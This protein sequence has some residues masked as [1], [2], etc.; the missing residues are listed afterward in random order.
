MTKIPM[1]AGR[2]PAFAA[3]HILGLFSVF[4]LALIG[5]AAAVLASPFTAGVG[6][7]KIVTSSGLTAAQK[8]ETPGQVSPDGKTLLFRQKI[9]RLLAVTGPDNDMLSYR[10][11]GRRNPT[12]VV[13][14]GATIKMLFVNTDDDMKHNVRIGA[15]L[16]AYPSVMTSYLETSVGTPELAHKSGAGYSGE[17][18]TLHA[19]TSPGTFVY[20]CTVRGHAQG[21]MIGKV[22][23][24]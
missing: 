21:G 5:N 20:L 1:R 17:E 19:P 23:V 13:P 8:T 7:P 12:L 11:D 9:I 14:P 15:A 4:S 18:L 16:K 2:S 6:A 10:I 3:P 24:Q 22:V